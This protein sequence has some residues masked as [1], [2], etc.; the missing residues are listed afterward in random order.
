MNMAK[1]FLFNEILKLTQKHFLGENPRPNSKVL[2]LYYHCVSDS[3]LTHLKHLYRYKSVKQFSNDLEAM[4]RMFEPLRI[5]DFLNYA[6]QPRINKKLPLLITF[7]DGLKEIYDVIAPL[8]LKKGIPA[9]FFITR[10]FIDNKFLCYH[11][12]ASILLENICGFDHKRKFLLE[13]EIRRN[14]NSNG[15]R[16]MRDIILNAAFNDRPLIDK[17]S[18]ICEVD[19]DDYLNCVKPYVSEAQLK[20]LSKWGF[21]IGGHATD[22]A[23]FQYLSLPEQIRQAEDS[24]GYVKENLDLKYGVF[25]FPHSDSGVSRAFFNCIKQRGL[26]DLC[27]G[28]RGFVRDDEPMLHHR[29]NL[30]RIQARADVAILRHLLRAIGRTVAGRID[31]RRAYIC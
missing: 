2:C 25:S 9:T 27:F 26:I 3:S 5:D 7:D 31:V 4:T 23:A 24:V 13:M 11:H 30:E 17:L 22:H 12:R 20:D 18:E 16:E 10:D 29:L 19:F 8:L 6:G 21:G 14:S 1:N 28:T 15:N